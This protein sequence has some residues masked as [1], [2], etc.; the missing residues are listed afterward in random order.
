MRTT[1]ESDAL[2]TLRPS[3]KMAPPL[4]DRPWLFGPTLSLASQFTNS[5]SMT[6]TKSLD[7]GSLRSIIP[8]PRDWVMP[9]HVN[10]G[11]YPFTMRRLMKFRWRAKTVLLLVPLVLVH[12]L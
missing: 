10:C 2:A 5:Q 11:V 7:E 1:L 3:M 9:L 6:L 12:Q 4:A 8:P